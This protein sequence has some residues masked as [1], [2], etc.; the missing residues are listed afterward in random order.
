MYT[1]DFDILESLFEQSILL[2]LSFKVFA[3]IN[4]LHVCNICNL[5][6]I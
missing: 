6:V 2:E 1:E 4:F 5:V 3:K